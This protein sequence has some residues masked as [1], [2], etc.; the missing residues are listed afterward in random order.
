[1]TVTLP[2][3]ARLVRELD[4]GNGYASQSSKTVHFGLGAV[5]RVESVEIRWPGGLVERVTV[6][7]DAVSTLREGSGR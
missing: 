3:G 2:G 6:P 5:E 1:V 4:G 7:L